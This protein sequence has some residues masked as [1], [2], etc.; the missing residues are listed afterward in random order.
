MS[1]SRA[2]NRRRLHHLSLSAAGALAS[3]APRDA[4]AAPP[5]AAQRAARLASVGAPVTGPGVTPLPAV[6]PAEAFGVNEAFRAMRFGAI[7][8]AGWTRWTVQWFNVQPEPGTF[9]HHYF[10]DHYGESVL[11]AQ[12]RAG[13]KV[14]AVVIGTPEWAATAP[15]LKTGTSV[16]VGLY[17]PVFVDDTNR[18]CRARATS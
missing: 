5:T 10:R 3:G 8:G 15:G 13:T 17:E 2:L 6:E 16:P 11:E 7:S 4:L 12:V 9:N 18:S 1:S 14:A